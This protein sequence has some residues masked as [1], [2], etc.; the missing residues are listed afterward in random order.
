MMLA[1]V[2]MMM[3][4]TRAVG[5]TAL[6]LL[7]LILALGCVIIAATVKLIFIKCCKQKCIK[8]WKTGFIFNIRAK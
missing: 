8:G 5:L 7:L 2:I 3:M 1:V 4:M 6:C